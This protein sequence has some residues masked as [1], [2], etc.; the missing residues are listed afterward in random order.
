MGIETCIKNRKTYVMN[1]NIL[2][3]TATLLLT[4]CGGVKKTQKAL[5][6][7]D[8]SNAIY[9]SINTLAKNKDKKS[10]QP[11]ILM[12]EEAYKKNTER[13]LSQIEFLRNDENPANY[14][15]IYNGYVNLNKIQEKIKT[16]TTPLH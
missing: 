12:L 11:Y 7:G 3:F 4:A 10:N 9:S 13:E 5:N 15:D 14:E 1:K 2:F 6:I 16:A 8:Y